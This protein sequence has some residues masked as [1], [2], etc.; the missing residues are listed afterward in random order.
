MVGNVHVRTTSKTYTDSINPRQW[1]FLIEGLIPV[2]LALVIWKVLPDS[3]E[4]AAFLTQAERD[5]LVRRL[6]N[7]T[8]SGAGKT[9]NTD[10]ID[11]T[12]IL[13]GLSDWKIWVRLIR[14][15]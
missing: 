4:T 11:K 3:P 15:N 1:I 8:S 10:K 12:H 2:A 5:L 7:D 13:A 6:A 9:T 14:T